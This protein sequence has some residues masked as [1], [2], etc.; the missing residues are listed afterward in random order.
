TW[1]F[2]GHWRRRQTYL[3]A[4]NIVRTVLTSEYFG[5]VVEITD[6]VPPGSAL[7]A[8]R[9]R[10]RSLVSGKR[11]VSVLHYFR[12]AL[13]EV[14]WK[15]T[16]RHVPEQ[17]AMVQRFRDIAMAVGGDEFSGIRCGKAGDGDRSAKADIGDGRLTGQ[18]EDIGEVDF[19]AAWTI[20]SDGQSPV[21]SGRQRRKAETAEDRLLIVSAGES[22]A[23]ALD[24]LAEAKQAGFGQLRRAAEEADRAF[25]RPAGLGAGAAGPTNGDDIREAYERAVLSLR[26]LQ[27]AETGAILAAPEFDPTYEECGGYGYVWPR[28]GA[29][30]A[31]ALA[32]VGH[33]DAAERF[34]DWCVKA[35]GDDGRWRQRYWADGSP[36]PTWCPPG[37]REQLDQSATVMFLAGRLLAG[38]RGKRRTEFL[39]RYGE[40]IDRGAEALLE[41]TDPERMHRPACDLW[42]S[43]HGSFTYTAAALWGAL[44]TL[45]PTIGR[46]LGRGA[47]M[48]VRE[49][50]KAIKE[51]VCERLWLGTYLARGIGADGSVDRHV[52]SSVLGV[53]EPFGMLSLDDDAE[54]AMIELSVAVIEEHLG[55]SLGRGKGIFR[56]QFDTY[57]AGAIGCVNTLWLAQVL[58]RLAEWHREGDA[59]LA[60]GYLDR[61]K[62]YMRFCLAH[63][64]PTGLFPELIG[65][66]PDTPYWAAP[67]GWASGLFVECARLLRSTEKA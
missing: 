29:Y 16:V 39:G 58:L 67:H 42:E 9:F 14:P 15:Q 33:R 37:E 50:Q 6:V 62:S 47:E 57:L 60:A 11:P 4:T 45:R 8:R 44:G 53:L 38:T 65:R 19:A 13:G 18:T 51:T 20:K 35:Q 2:E 32:Q 31:L 27:D 24:Q 26:L 52:D 28:D 46:R 49:A 64:S 43:F 54:R 23:E 66:H 17:G 21:V 5:L 41:A 63:R 3:D 40:M 48:R 34:L 22:E 25:V 30:A 59:K 61:A 1:L 55:A 10:L 56:F 7:L 36:G 12:F